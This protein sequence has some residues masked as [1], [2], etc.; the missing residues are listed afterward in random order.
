MAKK[1]IDATTGVSISDIYDPY[2]SGEKLDEFIANLETTR[3]KLVDAGWTDLKIQWSI[4]HGYYDSDS[5]LQVEI[6]GRRLETDKEETT[7]LKEEERQVALKKAQ[8]VKKANDAK[9]KEANELAEY[10][11]LKAKFEK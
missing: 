4:D 9:R 2:S 3:N 8:E 11:R 7:R 1:T 5:D 10:Q 6:K